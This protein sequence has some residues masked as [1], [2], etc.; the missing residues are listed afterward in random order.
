VPVAIKDQDNE[1]ARNIEAL[2]K[3]W[4]EAAEVSTAKT[5]VSVAPPAVKS[6]GEDVKKKAAVDARAPTNNVARNP[7]VTAAGSKAGVGAKTVT[8]N[9]AAAAALAGIK[10]PVTVT[11]PRSVT[12]VTL[13]GGQQQQLQPPDLHLAPPSSSPRTQASKLA[14]AHGVTTNGNGPLHVA[15]NTSGA[16]KS[17]VLVERHLSTTQ[18]SSPRSSLKY[19]Q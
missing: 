3:S 2:R 8:S 14:P 13:T 4:T 1:I 16:L 5:Q 17:A 6:G 10:A 18:S 11:V 15:A 7:K 12:S 9:P 19:V